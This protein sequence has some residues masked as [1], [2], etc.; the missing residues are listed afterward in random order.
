[1]NSLYT[2]PKPEEPSGDLSDNWHE[3]S[4]KPALTGTFTSAKSWQL[5]GKVSAV[6]ERTFAAPPSLL[7]ARCS[8]APGLVCMLS[9]SNAGAFHERPPADHTR[10]QAKYLR[11]EHPAKSLSIAS[12]KMTTRTRRSSRGRERLRCSHSTLDVN[13]WIAMTSVGR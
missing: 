2:N 8:D 5:Y 4:V 11:N 9:A 1:M 13:R 12:T 10:S 6:G 3:S 7:A